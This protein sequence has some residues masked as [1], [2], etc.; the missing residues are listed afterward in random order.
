MFGLV[1][2]ATNNVKCFD[3]KHVFFSIIESAVAM[4]SSHLLEERNL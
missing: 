3:S 2:L 1:A 4:Q